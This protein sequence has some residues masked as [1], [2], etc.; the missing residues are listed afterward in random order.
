V[1]HQAAPP[2]RDLLRQ[3]GVEGPL[4]LLALRR[5]KYQCTMMT[6][7]T[8]GR[9][10]GGRPI[11]DHIIERTKG[12]ADDLPNLVHVEI[13]TKPSRDVCNGSIRVVSTVRRSLPVCPYERTSPVPMG[14][15]Q[16]CQSATSYAQF[17]MKEAVS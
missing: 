9:G 17:G 4:R 13:S 12:G 14:M 15:P 6:C 3:S 7:T 10:T 16:T 8:P 11:V 1:G 2:P 5:D